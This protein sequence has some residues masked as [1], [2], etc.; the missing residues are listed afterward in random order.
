MS[1]WGKAEKVPEAQNKVNR[2]AA[3]IARFVASGDEVWVKDCSDELD[4]IELPTRKAMI[5]LVSPYR[6]ALQRKGFDGGFGKITA[7]VRG[8]N[9]YLKRQA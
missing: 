1:E 8:S 2:A 9:I 5:R 4:G 3:E 6:D 7:H